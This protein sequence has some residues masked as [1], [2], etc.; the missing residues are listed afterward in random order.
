MDVVSEEAAERGDAASEGAFRDGAVVPNRVEK[1]VFCHDAV[2]VM[3]EKLKNSKDFGL[4]G[5]DF[6]CLGDGEVALVHLY[7]G[8]PK[9]AAPM[10]HRAPREIF[11]GSEG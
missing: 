4:E 8:K 6:S 2:R 3:N 10:F 5:Q 1:F 11:I 7:I 9:D